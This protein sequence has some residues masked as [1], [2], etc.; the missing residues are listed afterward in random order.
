M[1][2][3][4]L[5]SL[6]VLFVLPVMS[7]RDILRFDKKGKFKI[8]QFTDVHY[9]QG[10]PESKVAI[11]LINEVLDAEK[12]DLV[13]FTGDIIWAEP[14]IKG[15]DEVFAPV[16]KRKV[17]WAYVF[18]NH[19]D[20]FGVTRE[21]LMEY[22]MQ[23]PY[24]LAQAGDKSLPGVGNYVLEVKDNT[25]DSVSTVLYFID[26]GS[27]SPLKGVGGYNWF[28]HDQVDW[29]R[30]E[31]TAYTKANNDTPYPG[32]AFFHIPL[33]EYAYMKAEKKDT[34]IGH[35]DEVECNGKLNTGMFAA[36]REH[37]DVLGT[38]V[39]HDHNNDYIGV[40]YD[41]ALAYGRY[42]GGKTVY[43]D[44]GLNGCRVIELSQD[45]REFT[46]YIRLLG[47]EKLFHIKYPDT[48]VVK[49]EEQK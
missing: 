49:K 26:S 12:P 45:K 42:S 35:K 37:G 20:E 40:Y 11:D 7:Q 8:V 16:V 1:K 30:R 44:L 3:N 10:L 36:M 33:A 38:F 22:A 2:K 25:A 18:G 6:L 32:L 31:S 19:D 23:K 46:S 4:V 14:V 41:I 9:K 47:G 29:Y 28:S 34:I 43:N 21:Q 17:P 27:Y 24:C 5:A 13:V 15:L 48:F 39:G